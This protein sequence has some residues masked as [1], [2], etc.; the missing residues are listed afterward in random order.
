MWLQKVDVAMVC[1]MA[2]GLIL[3][4]AAGQEWKSGVDWTEPPLVTPGVTD[5]AAPSDRG[6]WVR[7]PARRG[8]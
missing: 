1:V 2:F 8:V 5:D 3:A 7:R 6:A 4:P